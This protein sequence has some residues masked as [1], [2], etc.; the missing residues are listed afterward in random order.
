MDYVVTF[1]NAKLS[2]NI[3]NLCPLTAPRVDPATGEKL[4]VLFGLVTTK[5]AASEVQLA[6]L[7]KD[8]EVRRV[9]K[10]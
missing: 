9:G 5:G 8:L 7:L 1:P 10:P 3:E 6:S 4:H 2:I